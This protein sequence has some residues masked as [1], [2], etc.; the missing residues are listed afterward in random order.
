MPNQEPPTVIET[1]YGK[2]IIR[3]H[4]RMVSVEV[5]VYSTLGAVALNITSPDDA[6]KAAAALVAWA[7]TQSTTPAPRSVG[8]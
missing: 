5:T 3:P 7:D 4:D 6:C 2:L 8:G 1:P